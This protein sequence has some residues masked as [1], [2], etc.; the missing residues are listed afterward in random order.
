MTVLEVEFPFRIGRRHP[1]LKV[2]VTM[3]R[4]EDLVSFDMEYDM[5]LAIDNA[6]P[7]SKERAGGRFIHVYKF[8]DLDSAM[9][10]ME[11]RKAKAL[12]PKGLLDVERVEK[13]MDLFMERY[14]A[15]ERKVKKKKKTIVVSEDGFMKYA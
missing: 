5:D 9:E 4:K 15:G 14:E 2:D 12:P 1:K 7:K 8:V 11:S 13:E 10:F 6:E 3:E